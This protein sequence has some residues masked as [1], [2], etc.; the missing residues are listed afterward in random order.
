[1]LLYK[2]IHLLRSYIQLSFNF[3][4]YNIEMERVILLAANEAKTYGLYGSY[5]FT[6]GLLQL[7]LQPSQL[8]ALAVKLFCLGYV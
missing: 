1:M 5:G 2:Y 6:R 7:H 4:C 8:I 3:Q